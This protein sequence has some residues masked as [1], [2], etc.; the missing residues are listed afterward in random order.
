MKVT[1]F[2]VGQAVRYKPGTGTYGY[3]DALAES[4]D[5]RIAGVVVG[6]SPTRVRVALVLERGR[7]VTRSVEASSLKHTEGTRA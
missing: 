2:A 1:T 7:T 5:G 6:H 4:T 3:E